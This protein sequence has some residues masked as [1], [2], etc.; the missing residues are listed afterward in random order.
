MKTPH[1]LLM[2]GGT[3]G[4]IF[5]ALAVAEWLSV[6]GWQTT[7]L[8]SSGGME[9][10]LIPQHNISLETISIGGIRGKSLLT[11]LMFPL[12]LISAVIQAIGILRRIK[13]DVVLGMGG[14]ASGPG[15][16]AS[17][18]LG[19]PLCIHEQNAIAGMTNRYLAKV[20]Q[21]RLSAFP[22]SLVNATAVI[23]NPVRDAISSMATPEMRF[24]SKQ[25]P[26]NIL[27]VGG[28]RGAAILNEILPKTIQLLLEDTEV[29]VRHQ[30]GSGRRGVV[31]ERYSEVLSDTSIVME[32]TIQVSDFITDMKTAYQWAD[33]VVCRSGALTVSELAC[34]GVASILIPFPHAVDD[35]QTVNGQYLVK[36]DAA[37]MIQQSELTAQSLVQEI[38]AIESRDKC[39]TMAINARKLAKT[40]ATADVAEYCAKAA[41][42][43]LQ[44]SV[45]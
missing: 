21:F 13:P 20:A 6:R 41:G 39:L 1:I 5:P 30:A 27:V 28:S 18:L 40:N 7:W 8:G 9:E 23:G 35:H 12:Y 45:S 36:G 22:N 4:H 32:E 34:A 16:L 10:A 31:L 33:L 17:R 14:F 25:G 2:A 24:A 15:G 19:Y 37:R 44:E 26:L 11:K 42:Y 38:K 29:H 3:G 43:E